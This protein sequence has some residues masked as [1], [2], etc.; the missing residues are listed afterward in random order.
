MERKLNEEVAEYQA[1]KNIEEIADILEV[2]QSICGAR[3]FT[4]EELESTRKE[5]AKER[6][7]FDKKN[8]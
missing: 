5:K 7:G 8:F 6:G 2:L 3:G 4:L 1:N